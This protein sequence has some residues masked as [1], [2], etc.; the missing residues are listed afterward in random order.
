[1]I[2]YQGIKPPDLNMTNSAICHLM[3]LAVEQWCG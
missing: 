2:L 1:M 3:G